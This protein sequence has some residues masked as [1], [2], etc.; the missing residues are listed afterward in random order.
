MIGQP[1]PGVKSKASTKFI[2]RIAKHPDGLDS[3]KELSRTVAEVEEMT[4]GSNWLRSNYFTS[5]LYL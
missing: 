1:G 3:V 5:K 4:Q 2:E